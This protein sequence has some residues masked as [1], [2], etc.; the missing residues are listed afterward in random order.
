M[1]FLSKNQKKIQDLWQSLQNNGE[2]SQFIEKCAVEFG[3]SKKTLRQWWFSNYG[4]WSVP[5]EY[6]EQVIKM[7]EEET[8]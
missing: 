5:E 7:L 6:Q 4:D 2:K 3:K 1:E 8:K